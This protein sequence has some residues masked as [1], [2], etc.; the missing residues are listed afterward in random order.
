[1]IRFVCSD[2][3]TRLSVSEERAG[4]L[5]TC[6]KCSSDIVIPHP[7]T[8]IKEADDKSP[9]GIV[10]NWRGWAVGC[11]AA[12]VLLITTGAFLSRRTP[13][14]SSTLS[15]HS[16]PS[17]IP[18]VRAR[19][20]RVALEGTWHVVEENGLNVSDESRFLRIS[21]ENI[22]GCRLHKES[23]QVFHYALKLDEDG[24]HLIWTLVGGDKSS[25]RRVFY[26]FGNGD[27]NKDELRI[28]FSS[29]PNEPVWYKVPESK[30]IT[31]SLQRIK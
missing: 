11:V 14:T 30:R 15:T 31:W 8:P 16:S 1:M 27:A 7:I 6:P 29:D 17:P 9:R 12:V 21:T 26:S 13:S 10:R 25:L 2:C 24:H 5:A 20:N 22:I 3:K 18:A 19:E 4:F 23:A 28:T